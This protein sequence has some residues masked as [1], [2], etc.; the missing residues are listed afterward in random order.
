MYLH[1][2]ELMFS[3]QKG[4]DMHVQMYDVKNC[5]FSTFN[6]FLQEANGFEEL[7]LK[8]LLEW[9]QIN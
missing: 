7:V 5:I 6:Y 1:M 2:S 4:Q 9:L 3:L 8:P